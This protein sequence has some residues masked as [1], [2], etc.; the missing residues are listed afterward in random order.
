MRELQWFQSL[1]LTFSGAR[2][3]IVTWQG[4]SAGPAALTITL[5]GSTP[6]LQMKV[7]LQGVL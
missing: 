3:I 4:F 5:N 7:Q 1:S 6:A 2:D